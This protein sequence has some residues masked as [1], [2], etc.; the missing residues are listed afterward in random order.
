[1]AVTA[2]AEPLSVDTWSDRCSW[3]QLAV[4]LDGLDAGTRIVTVY[5]TISHYQWYA[6][7]A[8]AAALAASSRHD[9][10]GLQSRRGLPPGGAGITGPA[11]RVGRSGDP[12]QGVRAS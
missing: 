12:L 5:D 9:G 4:L 1:M 6:L 10:T 8:V 2:E 7:A 11:E 3:D